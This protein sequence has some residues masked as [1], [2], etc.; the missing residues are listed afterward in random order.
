MYEKYERRRADNLTDP[1]E[2]RSKPISTISG[3]EQ[4]TKRILF[5]RY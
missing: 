1:A 5:K 4:V 3:W 2:R